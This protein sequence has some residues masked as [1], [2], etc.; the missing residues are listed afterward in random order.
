MININIIK[1]IINKLIKKH[2]TIIKIP[3]Q[4]IEYQTIKSKF[5]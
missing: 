2:I 5:D 1:N 4:L 3:K